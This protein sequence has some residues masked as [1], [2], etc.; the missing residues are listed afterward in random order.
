MPK[1]EASPCPH[2]GEVMDGATAVNGTDHM[3]EEGSACICISCG[4][5]SIFNADLTQRLP[6]TEEWAELLGDRGYQH[7]MAAWDLARNRE[8]FD[9]KY[10]T[11]EVI[12]LIGVSMEAGIE[13]DLDELNDVA[14]RQV[15]GQ[16]SDEQL[17]RVRAVVIQPVDWTVTD[18]LNVVTA[19]EPACPCETC[20]TGTKR[21]AQWLLHHPGGT[22]ALGNLFYAVIEERA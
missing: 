3:P 1:I 17:T 12:D 20:S 9:E 4:K 2:C 5:P 6:T 15:A 11:R 21:A 7:A 14:H 13:P 10:V 19:F 16:F 18:D 22:V 8:K